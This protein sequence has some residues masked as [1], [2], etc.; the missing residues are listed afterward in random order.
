MR[1]MESNE[2]LADIKR[3]SW[4]LKI[5]YDDLH[6]PWY[7]IHTIMAQ[8]E[9]PFDEVKVATLCA[10][11]A[12]PG[13]KY[14]GMSVQEIIDS[15]HQ[16]CEKAAYR[17]VGLDTYIQAILHETELP[18]IEDE[19]LQKKCRQF[20]DFKKEVID[21]NFLKFIG[22]EIWI[23]SAK[24]GIRGRIDALFKFRD[25]LVVVD[26]KN[27][28]E[29][30]TSQYETMLGPLSYLPKSDIAKFTLQVYAYK[31]MLEQEFEYKVSGCRIIQIT[32]DTWN[33]WR[34]AFPYS[35]SKM[36]D[37][38]EYAFDSINERTNNGN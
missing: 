20:D 33:S 12:E 27:N 10:A 28:N 25:E 6:K 18:E 30:K 15:W 11:K 16:K 8:F 21:K 24:W 36:N 13:T 4:A 17:G 32:P 14:W 34:P 5:E 26:W 29:F 3:K 35:V 37:L 31:Y 19:E 38:F 22:S 9:K 23:N 1:L 7:S 2:I